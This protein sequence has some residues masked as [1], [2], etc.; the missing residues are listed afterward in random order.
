MTSLRLTTNGSLLD[1]AEVF[2]MKHP[3]PRLLST[4]TSMI[5]VTVLRGSLAHEVRLAKVLDSATSP[6]TN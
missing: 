1:I 2:D 6:V 5:E 3:P 4:I